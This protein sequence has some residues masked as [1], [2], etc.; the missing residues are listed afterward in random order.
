MACIRKSERPSKALY[1][2]MAS[3]RSKAIVFTCKSCQKRSSIVKR[4]MQHEY[5]RS[6][7]EEEWLASTR[8]LEERD[9]TV[10]NLQAE[11]EKLRVEKDNMSERLLTMA[12]VAPTNGPCVEPR[13]LTSYDEVESSV[14]NKPATTDSAEELERHSSPSESSS[15]SEQ[16]SDEQQSEG[17]HA[18]LRPERRPSC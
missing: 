14:K 5:E 15:T 10:A 17:S 12:T 16:S 4:L 18:G 13:T 8:L 7:V 9:R 1:E 6:R 2:A 3:C 11:I